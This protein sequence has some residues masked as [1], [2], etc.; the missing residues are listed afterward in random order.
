M[1]TNLIKALVSLFA[2]LLAMD[3]SAQVTTASMSGRVT[4]G[5]DP[6]PG[7]A[8]VARLSTTGA[9]Y[10]TTTDASGYY[11]LN[12]IAP[13][14]PYEVEVTFIGMQRMLFT[15]IYVALSDNYV[16]NVKMENESLTLDA[17]T[18][19]AEGKNS[20]MRSDRAGA[21]TALGE[22]EIVSV[23][24]V[25]RSLNDLL[26]QTPQAYVS[27]S[28]AY[29][30]GGSHRQSYVTV[31]GAA[32]N[33]A[34]GIGSNLP[35]SGSPISL[36]ALEQVAISITPYDVR[37]SG[38]IGGGINAVTKSGTNEFKGTAYV[39]FDNDKMQGNR[40][41]DVVLDRTMSRY[42]L[43]GASVGGPII[44]DKL[45][46]FL[47]VEADQSISPGPTRKLSTDKVIKDGVLVDNPGG[48]GYTNGSDGVARPN[49]GI[50]DAMGDYL[51]K[52][53]GYD[54]G[55]YNGYYTETPSFKLLARLDWN[56]ND[57]HRFNIRYS[58]TDSKFASSPSTS[59]TGLANSNFSGKSRTAMTAMYFKNA[60]YYQEQNFYSVAAELNSR[61]LEGRLNNM[62]R[63]SYSHQYEP[64]STEGGYFP[65]VDVVVAGDIYTSFGFEP[66]S[67]GNLRDVSTV[68][69]TDEVTYNIGRH[70]LLGGVQFEYNMTKNG[71][72]RF[73]AGY[74]EFDFNT[75]QDFLDAINNGTVFDNPAQFAITHGNNASFSQEFPRF[76][77]EQLSVY[78]QD[79]ISFS[80]RFKLSAG[81]RLELPFYPSLDFNYNEK[82]ANTQFAPIGDN[83][84][85][86]DTRTLPKTKVMLSPRIGFN[87]DIT[88]ER[89]YVL[90]GGTGIFTGRIPFV[91]IVAQAGD[92]G[93]LQTTATRVGT[94]IPEIGSNR[95][96]ILNQ[97]YPGGFSPE[98][99]GLNITS[100]TLMDEN[101]VMP[102]TWK[103]SLA[104]DVRLPWE[105]LASVEAV[106]NKDINPVTVTNIGLK[107][108]VQLMDRRPYY[109]GGYYDAQLK[110]AYLLTNVRDKSLWGYY[111]SI[112][113]KL[114]KSFF[115]G[116]SASFAY[117]Y[118]QAENINDGVGDQLY[119][120]WKALVNANGANS[121]EL[122][123]A[124]Y[125]MPHRIV[126]NVTYSRDYA[127]YFGTS[128]SLS[129]YGGPQ[130]RA[131]FIYS[132]NIVGDGAYS[133]NLIDIPTHEDLFGENKWIFQEYSYVNED[134]ENVV[135]TP[136][137]QAE[138]FWNFISQDKYLSKHTGQVAQ[139]NAGVYPWVHRF[140][141]KINQNF[142]FYT[143][144]NGKKHTIQLG[145][146]I[147]NVGN[148]L[149]SNWGTRWTVNGYDGYGNCAP[150]EMVNA[151]NAA[152]R[153]DEPVYKFN[154]DGRKRLTT[155]Y[156]KYASFSSTWS[157]MVNL[158][159][160]F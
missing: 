89:K 149:N 73:G 50:L 47:N 154:V 12:N 16:L 62:F 139:R 87:W 64:R 81:L 26:M 7:A 97:L 112:T 107:P 121:Q 153:G 101:L 99:A 14:G 76:E 82:V 19:S 66:F 143:G 56:I 105:M 118:S 132:N 51:R 80:D 86:Y 88:G 135:Y 110:D 148:L 144:R 45:F 5:S 158:R 102:Q 68:I 116:F 28:N 40:V 160:I 131:S 145:L 34:F 30:G 48:I 52:N 114:E 95:N 55:P 20:N 36:D 85:Y 35:A 72:Q 124:G 2:L 126:A 152:T 59:S 130:D 155:T 140:D 37:Q 21:I 3:M 11:S 93:V 39:Y 24:T 109:S 103:S 10:Y 9:K 84:G 83:D 41:G 43:Y 134:G 113:A 57:R 58:M 27:G 70:S 146:D 119:S 125:V 61:F 67:Y 133:Y 117:T 127:R 136:E 100:I 104:F 147:L 17:V 60:R 150:L 8:V 91:W 54:P 1:K 63:A 94:G 120:V 90:R 22:R 74:Y 29:I 46:F 31:D 44:K 159:Y 25:S 53:Y 115:K 96:E 142:Y 18:V 129:Y 111:Y 69:L 141:I 122:G 77:F 137:E 79:N 42:L 65:F 75:E 23:P 156:S 106:Y 33:N 38:F 138:D 157:M 32:F 92:A 15:D 78:L 123:Y 6:L 151:Y 13:G 49:G 71:F 108:P 4:D 98:A 128:V